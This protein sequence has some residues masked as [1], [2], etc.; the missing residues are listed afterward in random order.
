MRS[1]HESDSSPGRGDAL[2]HRLPTFEVFF[3]S[4]GNK[5]NYIDA[6][7]TLLRGNARTH[8]GMGI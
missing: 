8:P 3:I 6:P 5:M 4:P 2:Q 1:L 7:G